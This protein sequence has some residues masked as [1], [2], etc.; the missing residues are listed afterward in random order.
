[1]RSRSCEVDDSSDCDC[2][3]IDRL[4]EADAFDLTEFLNQ[5]E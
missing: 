1:M 3:R 2:V 5:A 4:V